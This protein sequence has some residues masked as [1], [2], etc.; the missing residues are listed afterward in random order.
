LYLL[1]VLPKELGECAMES[2]I[3]Y[4]IMA[5][6]YRKTGPDNGVVGEVMH[7]GMNNA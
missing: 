5:V 4:N 1:S 3:T 6:K 2:A 7:C